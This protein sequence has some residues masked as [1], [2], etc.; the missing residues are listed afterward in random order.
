[1][2][3]GQKELPPVVVDMNWKN[4]KNAKEMSQAIAQAIQRVVEQER[5]KLLGE[6]C[7]ELKV[8]QALPANDAAAGRMRVKAVE[9]LKL[10]YADLGPADLDAALDGDYR[11]AISVMPEGYDAAKMAGLAK[12]HDSKVIEALTPFM[13]NELRKPNNLAMNFEDILLPG[14][15]TV[16]PGFIRMAQAFQKELKGRLVLYSV[17]GKVRDAEAVLKA[18]G[19]SW[20]AGNHLY[21]GEQDDVLN[22]VRALP[23]LDGKSCTVLMNESIFNG[24]REPV[25]ASDR[26]IILPKPDPAR[27]TVSPVQQLTLG[28]V[29]DMKDK[30]YLIFGNGKTF[31]TY[32]YGA[33]VKDLFARGQVAF[34]GLP[35]NIFKE[36]ESAARAIRQVAAS[37]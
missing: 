9:K 35:V 34:I 11:S 29:A 25:G 24:I 20:L 5:W 21:I 13:R 3:S 23:G 27:F 8:L 16:D 15:R 32:G 10:V 30:Q 31:G 7:Q 33:V 37:A 22:R 19:L 18:A 4:G 6:V 14:T 12:A 2:V 26:M 17:S 36:I 1:M 28:V